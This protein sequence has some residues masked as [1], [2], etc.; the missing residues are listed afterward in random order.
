[1]TIVEA[2]APSLVAWTLTPT[3]MSRPRWTPSAGCS[4]AS[5]TSRP[6]R[7]GTPACWAGWP[8]SGPSPWSASRAR[9]ATAWAWPATSPRLASGSSR[10]T[11]PTVRTAAARASPL[12]WMRS[13]PPGPRSR[14]GRPGA[15]K[16]RD[17]AVEAI[18]ALMVAQR[19]ARSERVQTM[20]QARALVLTGPDDLR[21]RFARHTAASLVSGLASLR[22][23]PGDVAGTPLVPRCGSWAGRGPSSPAPS[24]SAWMSSSPR[25]S[26]LVPAACSPCAVSVPIPPPCSWSPPGTTPGGWL[27]GGLGAPVRGRPLRHRRGSHRHR[28]DPGG[29]HHRRHA[30]W[31][32]VLTRMSAH[33]PLVYVERRTREGLSKKMTSAP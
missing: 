32:I 4:S 24:S 6:P 25:S 12:R 27:G 3:C 15:P 11:A 28:L 17:G 29:D 16:G 19:S 33:P 7:P 2:R 1:M 22:P 20:N 31:R 10:W 30:L 23:R 8:G 13:A 5:R 21:T 18:R 26:P 9:A 14:A